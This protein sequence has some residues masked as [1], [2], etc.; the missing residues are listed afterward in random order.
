MKIILFFKIMR[1][2]GFN[3]YKYRCGRGYKEPVH[4]KY[5]KR[6]EKPLREFC[7]SVIIAI[8]ASDFRHCRTWRQSEFFD[9]NTQGAVKVWF[10]QKKCKIF[11]RLK[12]KFILLH[13]EPVEMP[14]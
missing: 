6:Y 14:M 2:G 8:F 4:K 11:W 12:N 10:V 7:E 1:T 13:P 9:S 3:I 5:E